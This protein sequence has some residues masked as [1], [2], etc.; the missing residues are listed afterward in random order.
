MN[1]LALS[2]RDIHLP[3]KTGLES[4]AIGWWILLF[5]MVVFLFFCTWIYKKITQ[6]TALKIAKNCLDQLKKDKQISSHQKIKELSSLIRQITIS[7]NSR[8][9]SASLTGEIWLEYLDSLGNKKIFN[10][11]LGQL[12]IYTPYQKEAPSN[13]EINQLILLTEEWLNAQS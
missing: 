5:F 8:I 13:T 9:D 7:E 12:L 1:P 11:A 2:L 6:K 4:F 3:E 10:S